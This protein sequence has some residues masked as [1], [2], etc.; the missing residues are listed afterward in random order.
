MDFHCLNI[1]YKYNYVILKMD[2]HIL[3]LYT[4]KSMSRDLDR[5]IKRLRVCSIKITEQKE[6]IDL[7]INHRD[8]KEKNVDSDTLI[9]PLLFPN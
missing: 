6:I 8:K 5:E 4:L 7:I 3:D 1:G 9:D 2:Y